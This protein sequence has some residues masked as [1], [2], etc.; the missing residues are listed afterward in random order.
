MTIDLPD[1]DDVTLTVVSSVDDV[2]LRRVVEKA[3]GN[4]LAGRR[5]FPP[6]ERAVRDAMSARQRHPTAGECL[7]AGDHLH[8]RWRGHLVCAQ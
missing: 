8:D 3:I 4:Y 1:L 7:T 6:I 2:P 5:R